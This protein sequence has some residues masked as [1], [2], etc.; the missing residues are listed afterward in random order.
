MSHKY[1]RIQTGLAVG[2]GAR[3]EWEEV[4]LEFRNSSDCF[5]EFT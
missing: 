1:L 2:L 5:P 3:S 4:N